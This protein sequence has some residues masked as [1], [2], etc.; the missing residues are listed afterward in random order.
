M[1][2]LSRY[3]FCSKHDILNIEEEEHTQSTELA[4]GRAGHDRQRHLQGDLPLSLQPLKV[5]YPEQ[6]YTVPLRGT[7]PMLLHYPPPGKNGC[8]HDTSAT[9]MTTSRVNLK[10]IIIV[11]VVYAVREAHSTKQGFFSGSE[12]VSLNRE[13]VFPC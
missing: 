1:V 10:L 7:V 11:L 2:A 12:K 13:P 8:Q 5:Q 9:L 3:E 6:H 4:A